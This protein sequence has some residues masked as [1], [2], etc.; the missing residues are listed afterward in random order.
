MVLED[1]L[2]LIRPVVGARSNYNQMP[3]RIKEG[4][5]YH[6]DIAGEHHYSLGTDVVLYSFT[7]VYST[8]NDKNTQIK[9]RKEATI[10]MSEVTQYTGL[11][12]EMLLNERT[13]GHFTVVKVYK[14]KK[15]RDN[16][17]PRK[18]C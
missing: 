1:T 2:V 11:P 10:R 18:P 7:N 16:G 12:Q 4:Q 6:F 9:K 14:E 3:Q 5:T 8:R 15:K 17:K 13:R